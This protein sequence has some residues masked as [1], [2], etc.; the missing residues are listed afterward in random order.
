MT[1][2]LNETTRDYDQVHIELH[3]K[4]DLE[5]QEVTGENKFTFVP[6]KNNFKVL[7][8]HT[9][10]IQSISAFLS[11]KQ[12]D[13]NRDSGVVEINLG[14]SFSK[15]DTVTISIQ[16]NSKPEEGLYFFKPVPGIAD[17]PYQ[18]WSQGEGI[19]N[20][21]WFPCYDLPDDKVTTDLFVDVP[22]NMISV[23]NGDLVS[24]T[25]NA[26][27]TTIYHWKI[28]EPQATYLTT[29][30][31]G[32]FKT[33]RENV[34]GVDLEYNVSPDWAD[35]TD[36][37][38][39]KTPSML[40]FYSDYIMPYPFKRY[41]QTPVQDFL[42]GGMENTSATTLNRR[43]LYDKN[44]M[45][46]YSAHDLVAHEFAHQWWGDIVTCKTWKHIWINE[47]FAT[48]FT[49]MWNGYNYG[50]DEYTIQLSG[51]MQGYKNTLIEKN[52]ND[53]LLASEFAP[54]ALQDDKAYGGGA[55]LLHLLKYEVGDIP[56]QNGIRH[57]IQKYKFKT[58]T[59]EDFRLA[60]E[61]STGKLLTLF[62]KQWLYQANIPEIVFSSDYDVNKQL[63]TIH[64]TQPDTAIRSFLYNGKFP[65]R[66]ESGNIVVD[67]N[68]VLDSKSNS[69]FFR[70]TK[71]PIVVYANYNDGI[72]CRLQYKQS[73]EE[74]SSIIK[75]SE[76]PLERMKSLDAIQSYGEK[77]VSV[78]SAC[79]KI[80]ENFRVRSK[81]IDVIK[82]F[83]TLASFDIIEQATIDCD[84]RVREN[85]FHALENFSP[86]PITELL[87]EKILSENN[88]YCKAAIFLTYGKLKLQDY[89]EMMLV[90]LNTESHRNI[91]RRSAFEALA[92]VEDNR[93]LNFAEQMTEY[94]YSNGDMHQ[95]EQSALDYAEKFISKNREAVSKIIGKALQN[96]YFRT[97]LSAARMIKKYNFEELRP[98]LEDISRS[99]TRKIVKNELSEILKTGK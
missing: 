40:R 32:N 90:A 3:L 35:R 75:F 49:S 16:Y 52:F 19:G 45:P 26:D 4:L 88:E 20:R 50:Q 11:G 74:L 24:V 65:V 27:G 63:L 48:Y 6:L 79:F 83:P 38:F 29:L 30:I 55:S 56:F 51:M 15:E 62:F 46:N 97:R 28:A 64:V 91:I 39:G 54:P 7:R 66:I 85:A 10:S 68:L 76:S 77:I 21:H 71:V 73:F 99:E 93:A 82:S 14:K 81:M 60:M 87:R 69:F 18:V 2:P 5:K 61:E 95:V 84:G 86:F 53:S 80:E 36:Y 67:T 58:A 72:V 8:L 96:P 59:T 1:S 17:I 89:Y 47:G 13:L 43:I 37:F 94:N 42:F 31:I 44:V 98:L 78:V 23:S 22:A 92:F 33:V 41:A 12:L 34:L 70:I 57:F 9:E 25:P